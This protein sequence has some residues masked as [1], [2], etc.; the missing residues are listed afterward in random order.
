MFARRLPNPASLTSDERRQY[1]D[2]FAGPRYRGSEPVELA[3]GSS[4]YATDD[5][6]RYYLL[7]FIGRAL[8][9]DRRMSGY[10]RSTEARGGAIARMAEGRAAHHA[11][12]AIRQAERKTPHTLQ[13][14]NVLYTS[15]G[16]EQT[17]SEF[18]E[19]T[20]VAGSMVELRQVAAT[21]DETGSM[22]GRKTALPGRYVGEPIR[23][24]PR[25]NNSVRINDVCDAW[26]WDGRARSVSWYG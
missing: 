8:K 14:G 1:R 11:A 7:A 20:G 6:S 25:S 17:N 10:Y 12:A 13:R 22:Q 21:L 23:R 19:V 2:S 3:D 4:Y 5:S 16:Y 18:Y 24:R 15:W 26:L 9:P